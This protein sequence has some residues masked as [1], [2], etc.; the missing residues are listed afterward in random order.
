MKQS[1]IIKIVDLL[2]FM[3]LVAMLA[4]GILIEY[5]LP[6]RSGASEVW[7]LSRHDWGDIHFYGS[8]I[9]LILMSAHLVTH[10]KYIKS[11]LLGKAER[12]YKYRIAIG[13]AGL[14]ALIIF[15]WT[16]ITAPVEV[17]TK[18]KGWQHNTAKQPL[19]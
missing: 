15:S 18:T 2:S 17:N 7:G 10:V 4:T 11:A 1:R 3:A 5:S 9:F 6:P 13:I 12:E 14:I 8:L 19:D 16:L